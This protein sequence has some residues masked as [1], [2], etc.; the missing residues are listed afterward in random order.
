[1]LILLWVPFLNASRSGIGAA[2]ANERTHHQ[3]HR[4]HMHSGHRLRHKHHAIESVKGAVGGA[5]HV[6][7]SKDDE[8]DNEADD[9]DADSDD[10]KDEDEKSDSKKD[11]KDEKS[12]TEKDE[13]DEKSDTKKE[14]EKASDAKKDEEE[15]E[16]DKDD[17]EDDDEKA[18]EDKEA[19]KKED[20]ATKKEKEAEAREKELKAY[21]KE[22]EQLETD[23]FKLSREADRIEEKTFQSKIDRDVARVS[24][25]TET[26]HLGPLLGDIRRDMWNF[27]APFYLESVEAKMDALRHQ[28]DCLKAKIDALND[29][30]RA[31]ENNETAKV[32]EPKAEEKV[33]KLA[34]VPSGPT[35]KF[36]EETMPKVS[37]TLQCVINLSWQYFIIYTAL[38]ILRTINQF[39][40]GA[41]FGFQKA[42]E[43]TCA[44]VT[45]APMLSVLFIGTR[46]RAIQLTQ[47]QTEKY[48]LPQPW[49]Q[50]AMFVCTFSVLIQA[51]LVITIGAFTGELQSG[52]NEDGDLKSDL[53][54][55]GAYGKILST[56]RY[57][58]MLGLYGG[59]GV[60]IYGIFTMKGPKEIWGPEGTPPVS[61]AV[62]CT[63]NL[64]IQFFFVYIGVAVVKTTEELGGS[65]PF[66][67]KLSGLLTLARYTVNF[68]PMLCILFIGARMRALQMDPKH[69]NPQKWAQNCFFLCTYSVL[70]QTLLV[71]IMPFA[72]KCECKMGPSEG[73][74]IFELENRILGIVMTV[75]RYCA[76]LALYGGF[77]AV[78]VSVFIIEHPKDVALTPPI[79]PAMQCVMNLTVQY[80]T[81][82]LALFVCITIKQFAPGLTIMSFLIAIFEAGQKTVMFAPM[83]S[84]LFIGARMRALQL[85]MA[86]DD[87]IPPGAGPQSWA[88]Q[89]MFLATWSVLVQVIMTIVVPIALGTGKPEMD[90]DGNL[91]T[92]K[93][94]NKIVGI[95]L[96]TIRYLCLLSMYGGAV[97]VM[98]AV[99]TMTPETLPPYADKKNLIPGVDVPNPPAPPT[100]GF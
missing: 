47:G 97:T 26:E 55:A 13:K 12:D 15:S 50:N 46:M 23:R 63:I 18:K 56:L 86:T 11:E 38:A 65:S 27:A 16:D 68:A 98:Y 43:A 9:D 73:D 57:L 71:I 88:Q 49:V 77:T 6:N 61:P 31:S 99:Y 32:K 36:T 37:P 24:E 20:E 75:I 41:V 94:T 67:R 2:A 44:T 95:I 84:I 53:G 33:K 54:K 76:L 90:A 39:T 28:E 93:G 8:A 48:Q 10:D 25:E 3:L 89:G 64:T 78:M 17:E 69:G 51:I 19:K 70:L 72:T 92:P 1:M 83:L 59:V 21:R 82:Y 66:I 87:T 91:K 74:V 45:F 60:V 96:D 30:A 35:P 42:I 4:A 79:S 80:F 52:V 62:S 7:K 58:V 34:E 29:Q 14:D 81:I 40:G 5:V 100:P 22:L 85:T